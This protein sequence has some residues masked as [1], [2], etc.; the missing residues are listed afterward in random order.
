MLEPSPLPSRLCIIRMLESRVEPGRK[1]GLTVSKYLLLPPTH[2]IIIPV[3]KMNKMRP[4]E[5][6]GC[7]ASPL[8][9]S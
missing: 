5:N 7:A 3:L 4:R 6:K 9:S 1:D 8:A 2:A